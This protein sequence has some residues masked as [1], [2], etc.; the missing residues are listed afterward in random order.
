MALCAA[1]SS[2]HYPQWLHCQCFFF[3]FL[4]VPCRAV[5]CHAVPCTPLLASMLLPSVALCMP[6]ALLVSLS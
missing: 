5:P 6:Q 4:T 3:F 2:I 1:G